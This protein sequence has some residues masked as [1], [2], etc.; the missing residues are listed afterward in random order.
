MGALPKQ[1]ISR[2]R[3]GNRRRHHFITVASLVKCSN[4][5]ATKQAHHVCPT[6]G[7]Y[8]GREVVVIE[9]RRRASD[10]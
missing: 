5:N 10:Q 8:R 2:A 4:C 7:Y 3:Q 6:C 1:R 9:E